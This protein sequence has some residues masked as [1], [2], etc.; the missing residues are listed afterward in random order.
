MKDAR[1]LSENQ[2]KIPLGNKAIVRALMQAM[3]GVSST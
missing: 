3:N 2:Y 1:P